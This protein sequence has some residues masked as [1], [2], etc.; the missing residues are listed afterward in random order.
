MRPRMKDVRAIGLS[1]LAAMVLLSACTPLTT[2]NMFISDEGYELVEAAAYGPH[3][4]QRLDVMRPAG[5]RRSRTRAD[6][7][8]PLVV[9]FY[10]GSWKRGTRANYRFVGEALT[11]SGYVVAIPDYGIYPEVRFPEF[12]E[13]GARAVRWVRDNAVRFGGDP[14]SVYLIGHSA[15]AHIVALLALDERYLTAAGVPLAVIKGVVGLSGPYAF[16][17]LA[18]RSVRPIF[19]HLADP[20]AARPITFVDGT[21]PPMLLLHGATDSTVDAAN[22]RTLADRIR[23]VGGRVRHVEYPREGHIGL[24]L[25]LAAPFQGNISVLD[26]INAFLGSH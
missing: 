6:G 7:A 1:G 18:T 8:Q 15:G 17:P 14:D 11:A 22:S 3:D 16:H 23:A 10:G 5:P 13:D 2:L 24:L 25:A 12:V 20:N 19:E 4:R 9:F 21:E 26:E